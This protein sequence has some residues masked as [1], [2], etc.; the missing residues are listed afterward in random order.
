[1]SLPWELSMMAWKRTG[2]T[3]QQEDIQILYL[4]P[5]P[6]LHP[7]W[8]FLEAVE[9]A[10]RCIQLNFIPVVLQHGKRVCKVRAARGAQE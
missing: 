7:L 8:C 6:L 2:V 1:M 3:F 10:T 9:P 4:L 5:T